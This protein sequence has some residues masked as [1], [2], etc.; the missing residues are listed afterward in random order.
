MG[1]NT[2]NFSERAIEKLTYA[3]S[4]KQVTYRDSGPQAVPGLILLVSSGAKTFYAYKKVN[5]RPVRSRLGQ[6]PGLTVEDARK[7]ARKELGKMDVG[8]TTAQEKLEK[9]KSEKLE[10]S[11]Q[12]VFDSWI[13]LHAK[14][15]KRTW[16]ADE[17]QFGKY[18][19]DWKERKLATITHSEITALHA[20]I[21]T[22]NG[23]YAANRLLA[24]L[25]SLFNFARRMGFYTVE[26]PCLDIEKFEEVKRTRFLQ[27]DE[28]P[29]FF[30][31]LKSEPDQ[32]ARDAILMMLYTG[33]RRDNVLSMQWK[34]INFER[35]YWT[36]PFGKTK[37]KKEYVVPFVDPAMK[38]LRER[39]GKTES[40]WVFPSQRR[41]NHIQEP[42]GPWRD[43]LAGTH[44]KKNKN[45]ESK[46]ISDLHFH[47][48][49]RTLASYMAITGTPELII[50]SMLGH[51][52]AS[53][54]GIYARLN[55]APVK[56]AMERAV[57]Y[58]LEK[59][60]MIPATR[61]KKGAISA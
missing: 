45:D 34:E 50:S 7:L 19:S 60:K 42:K 31:A 58:I 47:D 53:V 36:I 37:S 11:L 6:S 30:D 44:L 54:T 2:I 8:I 14:A 1:G 32:T 41:D 40:E 20:T 49:R 10:K 28:L 27:E 17:W 59:G 3:D 16:K 55:L 15:R 5:G 35:E 29:R 23:E 18:L 38:I 57:E 9:K 13:E 51:S 52:V 12:D 21:G 48:L 4:G 46:K 24:L 22:V 33:Q 39:Q 26:S 25:T 61:E 43:I 56:D